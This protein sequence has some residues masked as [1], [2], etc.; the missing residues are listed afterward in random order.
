MGALIST[1]GRLAYRSVVSLSKIASFF[2]HSASALHIARFARLHEAARLLHPNLED[3]QTSLLLGRASFHQIACVR[4]TSRRRELG[5]ILVCAP[6]RAGKSLHAISQ[7]LTWEGS[8][9]VNDV[10]GELYA[11]TAGFRRTFGK[12][13]VIDPTG[14]G[15]CYDPLQGKTTEDELYSAATHLLYEAGERDKIFTQRATI[16]LTMLLIA[17][18]REKVAPFPYIC[19][20]LKLGLYDTIERLYAID[21]HLATRFLGTNPENADLTDKFL[22]SSWGTLTARLQPL[23]NETVLRSLTG[24]DFTPEDIMCDEV[25]VTLYVKWKEQDLLALA[26]LV[27]LFWTSIIDEL[28]TMYDKRNGAGC[29][30]VLLL[31]DEGGRTAIPNLHDA[32]TTVCGRGISIWLVIQSLSQLSSVYGQTHAKVLLSNM[33][34]QLFYRPNDLDTAKYLEE[35]LGNFSAYAHSQTL[36]GGEE[37]SEGLS[38]RPR[39]LLSIQE[40]LQLKDTD[41]LAWH[42]GYKPLK[43]KRMDWQDFPILQ[44]RH[45]YKAPKL[46]PLPP[47]TDTWQLEL[48]NGHSDTYPNGDEDSFSLT[49]DDP[50]NL[51]GARHDLSTNGQDMVDPQTA[52]T[53][54]WQRTN[55][56]SQIDPDNLN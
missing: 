17:S 43:L 15:N 56:K 22:L 40:I 33:D 32:V 1:T 3:L 35:R 36:H 21:P 51:P 38:E 5:N 31:I 6:T 27:R 52:T 29:N 20:S 28:T 48:K 39:P 12:V 47:I 42:R 11:A 4:P 55:R 18:R 19:S 14:F 41:V 44:Q 46:Y 10:K 2:S 24:S 45:S 16:M 8:C 23:L 9:V 53:T 50:D 13:Y 37:K 30:P 54:V 26:P 34:T 25:P 49:L 7:L